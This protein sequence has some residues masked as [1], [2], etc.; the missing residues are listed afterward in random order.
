MPDERLTREQAWE[1]EMYSAMVGMKAYG[2]RPPVP[3]KRGERL[4]RTLVRAFIRTRYAMRR[5]RFSY[6]DGLCYLALLTLL[7]VVGRW[8]TNGLVLVCIAVFVAVQG[9]DG[10]DAMRRRRRD[11]RMRRALL[12]EIDGDE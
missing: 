6:F 10:W 12:G 7:H 5:K 2:A 1:Y 3:P 11:R 4:V 9:M 8:V